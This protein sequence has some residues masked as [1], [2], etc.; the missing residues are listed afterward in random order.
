MPPRSPR[1]QGHLPRA[2]G[3]PRAPRSQA[4]LPPPLPLRTGNSKRYAVACVTASCRASRPAKMLAVRGDMR[5]A[6]SSLP[7]LSRRKASGGNSLAAERPVKHRLAHRE[8]LAR[9]RR[10]QVE[11]LRLAGKMHER[12]LAWLQ[13]FRHQLGKRLARSRPCRDVGKAQPLRRAGGG[14][15]DGK[16]RKAERLGK[17]AMRGK[18]AQAHCGSSPARLA[19]P[20]AATPRRRRAR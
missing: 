17:L 9:Q 4:V 2:A 14:L 19:R 12:A 1:A 20:R 7:A 16:Q 18:R 8:A 15:A 10:F 11:G 3:P 5:M 6:P 13:L